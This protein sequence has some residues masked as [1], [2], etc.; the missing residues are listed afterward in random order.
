[1]NIKEFREGVINMLIEQYGLNVE[2]AFGLVNGSVLDKCL[3]L[4]PEQTMNESWSE[5][6]RS[7]YEN[8]GLG[9]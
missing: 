6:A 9:S 7:I 4:Y 3:A 1:M 8:R 5:W 2:A